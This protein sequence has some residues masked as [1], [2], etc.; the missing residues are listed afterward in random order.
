M[1]AS[2][3]T[4]NALKCFLISTASFSPNLVIGY[5][6][7]PNN[8]ARTTFSYYRPLIVVGKE[9]LPRGQLKNGILD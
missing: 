4:L 1:F 5:P 8:W 7:L 2:P 3:H 9:I 6:S